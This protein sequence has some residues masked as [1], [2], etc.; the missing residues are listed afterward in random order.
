MLHPAPLIHRLIAAPACLVG[1]PSCEQ[2]GLPRSGLA[3]QFHHQACCPLASCFELYL[4]DGVFP[5]AIASSRLGM[6]GVQFHPEVV[7][8]LSAPRLLQSERWLGPPCSASYSLHPAAH[9]HQLL[10]QAE[11]SAAAIPLLFQLQQELIQ[12]FLNRVMERSA[13]SF[14]HQAVKTNF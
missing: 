6:L 12:S 13:S 5:Q 8:R 7:G 14:S 4:T 2:L 11:L 1:H 9:L 3:Y 10:D